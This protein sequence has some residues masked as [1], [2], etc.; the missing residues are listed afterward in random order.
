LIKRLFRF[1]PA[2]LFCFTCVYPLIG[3][4]ALQSV[5]EKDDYLTFLSDLTFR[6]DTTSVAEENDW[7]LTSQ[8]EAEGWEDWHIVD[9]YSFGKDRGSLPM[10]ADVNSLHPFFRDKVIELIRLCRRRGIELRIVESFRTRA[11]QA[12]Y[13]SMG[14]KYTRS[15]GGISRHQYGLAVDLVPIINGEPGWDNKNLWKKIGLVG[16]SLGL[17]WGGRWR[18]LYDP[19]HFEW[20]GGISS[21]HLA[22]G[23][24]PPVPKPDRYPCLDEDLR[25]LKAQWE[26]WESEQSGYARENHV[27]ANQ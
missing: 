9:N 14:K 8:D 11:K 26:A 16:E 13:Y 21:Y 1:L 23:M 15:Q 19:A 10:I 5:V 22:R 12:E 25:I 2:F 17:R 24:N 18:S 20:T 7:M 6:F 4:S 3:Q 27:A